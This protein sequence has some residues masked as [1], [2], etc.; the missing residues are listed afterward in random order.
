MSATARPPRPRVLARRELL[1]VALRLLRVDREHVPVQRPAR[2]QRHL[3]HEVDLVGSE[4]AHAA[5]GHVLEGG[6]FVLAHGSAQREHLV[7]ARPARRDRLAV[8]VG[9][10]E[11]ER[12]REAQAARL[13]GFVQ[14]RGHRGELVGVR[15]VTGCLCTHHVA[16]QRAVPDQEADVDA[17]GAVEP[18]EVVTEGRPAPRHTL[19]EC[20]E[21][22]AL[23]LRH[24]A[25]Q[26][27]GIVLVQRREREAAVPGDHARDAV[28]ARRRGR[29]IPEQLRV[30]VRVRVDET[31]SDDE[32]VG[33]DDLVRA[34]VGVHRHHAPVAHPD[35][36]AARGRA[37]AVDDRAPRMMTS[38][39]RT[40]CR[41]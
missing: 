10:R 38:S 3:R 41:S 14:E 29:G 16:A 18:V 5:V 26:V 34:L 1:A 6:P 15:L 19:L 22:H 11:R 20:G 39:I 31:R 40:P 27:V 12:G 35:V 23:D 36:G 7:A 21:R 9:V 32:T 28:H 13:D 25:T 24:H 37:R 2:R 17:D 4:P 8:A 30:V 33:V